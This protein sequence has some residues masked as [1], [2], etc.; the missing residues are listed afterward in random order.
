MSGPFPRVSRPALHRILI[1][2]SYTGD[3]ERLLR[4]LT[5]V[6][7]HKYKIDHVTLQIEETLEGCVED[8]HVEHLIAR[9]KPLG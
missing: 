6:I 3:R 2:P 4:D 1:D 5:E 8:H 7:H 9:S